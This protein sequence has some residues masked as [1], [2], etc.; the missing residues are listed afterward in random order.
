MMVSLSLSLFPPTL[1][2]APVESAAPAPSD[3]GLLIDVFGGPPAP[4]AAAEVTIP[5]I[6]TELSPGTEE[7]FMRF[8]LKMIMESCLKMK[9]CKLESSRSIRKN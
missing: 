3:Q 9:C 1:S 6:A 7:G 4:V 2:L 5:P 8:L